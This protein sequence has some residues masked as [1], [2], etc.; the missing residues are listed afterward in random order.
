M[1]IVNRV[2]FVPYNSSR[3]TSL[4]A[5]EVRGRLR[6]HRLCTGE[7]TDIYLRQEMDRN[8]VIGVSGTD[9]CLSATGLINIDEEKQ[10]EL[11]RLGLLSICNDNIINA[12]VRVDAVSSADW[13]S[14]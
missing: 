14:W 3:K 7:R 1:L 8:K 10:L 6:G 5:A 9:I 4:V 13:D 2:Q 12:T 11:L